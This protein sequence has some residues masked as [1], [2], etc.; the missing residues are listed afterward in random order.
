MV[1]YLKKKRDSK[2]LI[3]IY[4]SDKREMISDVQFRDARRKSEKR[5]IRMWIQCNSVECPTDNL[6][7]I[8]QAESEIY[9]EEQKS[10]YINS[11]VTPKEKGQSRRTALTRYWDLYT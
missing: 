8:W 11:E 5:L 2:V 9:M 7:G 1:H 10:K 6:C 3:L 4:I